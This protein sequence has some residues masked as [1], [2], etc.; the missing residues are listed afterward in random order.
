MREFGG[1]PYEH[2]HER[3]RQLLNV[4]RRYFHA[5]LVASSRGV[6]RR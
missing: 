5:T 1:P 6:Q 4:T 2:E 3:D